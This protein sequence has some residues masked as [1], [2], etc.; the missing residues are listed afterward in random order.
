MSQRKHQA[1]PHGIGD[2]DED[3]WDGR[4]DRPQRIRSKGVGRDEH[5]RSSSNQLLGAILDG[6]RIALAPAVLD[7]CGLTVDPTALPEASLKGL[8]TPL[9][10][11]PA[12]LTDQNAND[13][14]SA[15]ILREKRLRE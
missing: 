5:L 2:V 9:P 15:P 6:A 1:V 3:D 7:T 13:P 4:G 8:N 10:L 14:W 12:A 11:F